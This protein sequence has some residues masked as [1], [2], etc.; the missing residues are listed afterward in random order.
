MKISEIQD[1]EKKEVQKQK[2]NIANNF[3]NFLPK[4]QNV[5]A[6]EKPS[7][8]DDKMMFKPTAKPVKKVEP[9]SEQVKWDI[10]DKSFIKT[11]FLNL[12]P[13]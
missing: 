10:E 12:K 9:T 1:R 5:K 4:P 3:L 6:S 13:A 2:D 11:E 8:M 7:F